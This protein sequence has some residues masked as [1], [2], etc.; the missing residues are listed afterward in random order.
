MTAQAYIVMFI[1]TKSSPAVVRGAGIFSET[2]PTTTNGLRPVPLREIHAVDYQ[3]ASEMAAAVLSHD[4]Y[5]WLGEFVDGSRP[6]R[7]V[8]P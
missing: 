1:D 6:H 7:M 8:K 2:H 3:S 5:A 4:E